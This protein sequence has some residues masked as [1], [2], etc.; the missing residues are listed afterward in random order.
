MFYFST[1]GRKKIIHYEGCKHEKRIAKNNLGTF[2]SMEKAQE[3]GYH[4]C[5]CCNPV[6]RFYR[7]SKK[8]IFSYRK[9]HQLICYL[10][11]DVIEI[12]SL[13]SKWK[14]IASGKDHVSL[15]HKNTQCR[16]K[17]SSSPVP[18]YHL[19]KAFYSNV[20][21]FLKYI[22]KHDKYRFVYLEK[23]KLKRVKKKHRKGSKRW[24]AEQKRIK[25]KQR[26]AAIKNVYFIFEQWDAVRL[27]G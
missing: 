11:E 1:K 20:V 4:L 23:E 6:A 19:Q 5:K 2:E 16:K 10:K 17:E 14:I 13:H 21:D 22:V 27:Y 15:F 24:R 3:A 25:R 18:G 12:K 7:R 8:D 26:K 9:E